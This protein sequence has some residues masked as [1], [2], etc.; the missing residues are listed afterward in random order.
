MREPEGAGAHSHASPGL[1]RPHRAPGTLRS[2]FIYSRSDPDGGAAITH[3]H[4]T[5]VHA[6]AVT[7]PA[8]P[9]AGTWTPLVPA[10]IVPSA[11]RGWVAAPVPPVACTDSRA[12]LRSRAQR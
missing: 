9:G 4:F 8:R 11:P 5:D 3:P 1:V 10:W 2:P 12:R 7:S 6:E